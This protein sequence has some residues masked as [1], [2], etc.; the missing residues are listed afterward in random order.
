MKNILIVAL[1]ILVNLTYAQDVELAF[2]NQ[3]LLEE[4][5]AHREKLQLEPVMQNDILTRAADHHSDYMATT[6]MVTHEEMMDLP[7]FNNINSPRKRIEHFAGNNLPE[8]NIFAEICLGIRIRNYSDYKQLAHRI[9]T[10]MLGSE[11]KSLLEFKDN[12]Y[13]G[14]SVK[15][16]KG[17]FY[18][19]MKIGLG[20]NNIVALYASGN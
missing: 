9:F 6:T 15:E 14:L 20:Y 13:A 7:H 10:E 16:K 12:L 8:D 18:T 5:N 2:L 17:T 4:I 11:N 3:A 19:T 1:T